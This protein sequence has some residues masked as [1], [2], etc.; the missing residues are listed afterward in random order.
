MATATVPFEGVL[1]DA[2]HRQAGAGS[3]G[4]AAVLAGLLVAP[5]RALPV[6]SSEDRGVWG[7]RGSAD[8]SGVADVLERAAADRTAPWPVPLATDAA[9]LHDD[10]DREG[11]ERI[12]FERQRRVARAAIA[13]AH[14][15]DDPVLGPGWLAEV[16]DGVWLICEQSS[17]CWPAHDDAFRE[18]G[19]VLP[20]VESP[21]LDLGAGEAVALLTWIDHLLGE[22][23]EARYPG[24]R[25][26]IRREA[27]VRVFEP[28]TLRR[29][30]HWIGLD[31][32]VHNWNPWIHGN[33]LT[34]ALRLLDD[35]AEADERARIVGLAIEGIDRYVSALPADGAIDEGY[36]YWWNGA[37]RALEALDIVRHA[38]G[39]VLDASGI[40]ALRETVAFPHRMHLGGD[41]YLNVADGQARPPA[42]Q[43]WHALHRAARS[44]GDA[45]AA[46]HAASHR[47]A[48]M[49]AATEH[50]GFGRLL[51][52]ITD[53]EWVGADRAASPLPR[54]V[55][56]PSTEVMLAREHGGTARGLT[57]AVK[58]G[59]N[60]E[61]HN[62]ND[63]GSFVVASDGVPV[64]VDA[65]RPT[66]TLQTF[67]EGRYD[68]WTMQSGWHNVPVIAGHEQSPGARFAA[69]AV[70]ASA[71]EDASS[72]SLEL[73]GAYAGATGP[74]RRSVRL[75][76]S[77][78]RV[79][80]EDRWTPAPAH[81][82]GSPRTSVRMLLAGEVRR[83]AAS[84]I[85]TPVG[86][87]TPVRISWPEGTEAD[88]VVRALD[89]P[90]L[91]DVWGAALTRLDL[92]VTTRDGIAVTV[93][94]DL[95]NAEDAR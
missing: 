28:F 19:S 33:V 70:A 25:S 5:G 48:G 9:R 67:G 69:A 93:E 95:T 45:D 89:D 63:V 51:R 41:W 40:P 78:R 4:F 85:V 29:D 47:I 10:G 72:L 6:A 87:A 83:E 75:E 86:P 23:L 24:I 39:G 50:E 62:H 44:A 91:A 84:V 71:D 81:E 12:V 7:A 79:V 1:A 80:V 3:A 11:W 14:H 74:W 52:G 68:I 2:Y 65:G 36:A 37:C 13:A 64:I 27:R 54:D 58:G 38:T 57:V 26:R 88:L 94:L 77:S 34:A 32:D 90:M 56:L 21:Y 18:R 42:A 82:P 60:G 61:H 49:P 73:S 22:R 53:P 43:P 46:A 17:W 30:W 76:R 59:H 16:L 31:G 8:P 66:Y 20:T 15:A 92:D 55:W 35:P